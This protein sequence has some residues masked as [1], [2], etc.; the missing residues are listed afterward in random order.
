[1]SL[2]QDEEDKNFQEFFNNL[3]EMINKIEEVF[4]EKIEKLE[5]KL[6]KRINELEEKLEKRTRGIF[7]DRDLVNG[8]LVLDTRS[9]YCTGR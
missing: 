2:D 9:Y 7:L 6:N 5:E 4:N 8:S 3:T 1:M